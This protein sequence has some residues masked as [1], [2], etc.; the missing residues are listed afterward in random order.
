MLA[1]NPQ[2][3]TSTMEVKVVATRRIEIFVTLLECRPKFCE[4]ILC[5]IFYIANYKLLTEGQTKSGSG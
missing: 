1:M 3:K 5:K 4:E 2:I